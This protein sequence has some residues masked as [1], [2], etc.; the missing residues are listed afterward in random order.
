MP[1]KKNPDSYELI[2]GKRAELLVI[3]KISV[4]YSKGLP[5]LTYN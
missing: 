5:L 2:R 1:Q 3:Y 4:L